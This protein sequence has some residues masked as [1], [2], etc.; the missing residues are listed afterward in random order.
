[1]KNS[2]K[3]SIIVPVYNAEK[4]IDKCIQSLINQTYQNWELI[5]VNDASTDDSETIIKNFAEPR[6]QYLKN[7]VNQGAAFSRNKAMSAATGKYL[8]FLDADDMWG[9]RK[10]EKELTA[11]AENHASFIASWYYETDSCGTPMYLVKS[12]SNLGVKDFYRCCYIG[13]L[14]AL[15]EREKI[16]QIEIDPRI[17][18]RNDYAMWLIVIKVTKNCLVIEEPLAYYRKHSGSVSNVSP[19]K[20]IKWHY[21]LFRIQEQKNPLAALFCAFRNAFYT[22]LKKKIYVERIATNRN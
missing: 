21:V 22:F 6:I 17:K 10:L 16:P 20:L 19:L 7:D 2:K 8:A 12:P 3:V 15:F 4:F 9:E 1:M 5:I 11:A 13:C 14:T 18:K